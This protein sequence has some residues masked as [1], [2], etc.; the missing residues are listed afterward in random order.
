[1]P[2]SHLN[3]PSLRPTTDCLDSLAS[4]SEVVAASA[5]ETSR[6]VITICND[7]VLDATFDSL[8]AP[9]VIIGGDI[10]IECADKGTGNCRISGGFTH[11]RI[12]A[13]TERVVFDS[14]TFVGSDRASVVAAG[15]SFAEAHF[16]N[17]KWM[18]NAGVVTVLVYNEAAGEEFTGQNHLDALQVPT[19][20]SMSVSFED[21]VFEKNTPAFSVVSGISATMNFDH[22]LFR[23][24]TLTRVGAISAL[25]SS[26]VSISSSCFIENSALVDGSVL[27][28]TSSD[29]TAGRN[30]GEGNEARLGGCP[31][32]FVEAQPGCVAD[33]NCI[34]D[35]V[36]FGSDV[37]EVLNR[38][39]RTPAPSPNGPSP[40]A[41][42]GPA[43]GIVFEKM[44]FT[45]T[46]TFIAVL[47]IVFIVSL[48]GC[49]I[50]FVTL[51]IQGRNAKE[52]EK[53]KES[54]VD[55][56]DLAAGNNEEE[57]NEITEWDSDDDDDDYEG[58]SKDTSYDPR[59]DL[60]SRNLSFLSTGVSTN[61]RMSTD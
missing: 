16:V 18:N 1:M 12:A 6:V 22:V 54:H 39:S 28:D 46:G 45:S 34:G 43:D 49:A 47:V 55:S 25:S 42:G 15:N 53:A 59:Y 36:E 32:I 40:N 51:W 56:P 35:C 41:T 23:E 7:T 4:L 52:E 33:A 50:A 27:I 20:A 2:S 9:I 30:F 21:C 5:I 19:S 10:V 61:T 3:P 31:N 44:S 58:R 11:F 13:Q 14:I 24:N 37:C 48:G 26:T 60:T 38:T 8:F 57:K 17:C 29:L